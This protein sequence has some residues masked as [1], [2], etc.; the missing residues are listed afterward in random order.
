MRSLAL[1]ACCLSLSACATDG[2]TTVA[3]VSSQTV[4]AA[5]ALYQAASIAGGN[6]VTLG[7][8][9]QAKYRDLDNQAYAVLLEIRAGKAT[10]ADLQAITNQLG[11]Q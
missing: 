1:L 9:D 11:A 6:L 7:K 2:T 10:I 8:L 3:S 4:T 5:D